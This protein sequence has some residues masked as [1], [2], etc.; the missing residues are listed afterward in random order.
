MLSLIITC[1]LGPF[2]VL[3]YWKNSS[4]M[5]ICLLLPAASMKEELPAS[6]SMLVTLGAW[7]GGS[8]LLRGD[9]V[10]ESLMVITLGSWALRTCSS[11]I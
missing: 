1:V 10:G 2:M 8:G 3:V 11:E 9:K 6:I 5:W 7:A 4:S